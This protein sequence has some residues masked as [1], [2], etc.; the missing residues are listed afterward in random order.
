[1]QVHAYAACAIW[2]DCKEVIRYKEAVADFGWYDVKV[3][4]RNP[5]RPAAG[6]LR[7]DGPAALARVLVIPTINWAAPVQGLLTLESGG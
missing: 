1:M 3:N 2:E 6:K 7:L 5:L 4:V